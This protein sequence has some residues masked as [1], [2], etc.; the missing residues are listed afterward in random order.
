MTTPTTHPMKTHS[1]CFTLS[2]L[3]YPLAAAIAFSLS[4]P[5]A[6]AQGVASPP[7]PA[8]KV[9]ELSPF[10][11]S[12]S[13]ED[14]YVGQETL[15]G[16]R[17]RTKLSDLAAAIS[18]MTAEF[19][20]DIAVSD[21]GEAVEYAL[22][23][24]Q[25]TGDGSAAAVAGSFMAVE[26]GARGIRIRGLP[27][28][29]RSLNYFSA[30][31]EI[32]T[33]MT[34]GI[35]VSR[36][37]NSI[38][39]GL[40]SPA[41]IVNV[42]SK[43][44]R[45]NKNTYSLSNR[46]DS[47]G[48][49]RWIADANLV[50]IKDKLGMRV[51]VLNGREE[52]WR[53]YGYN[54]QDRIF[55]AAKWAI[56]RK[57]TLKV[58]FEHG[59][60]DDY[61]P[62]P[63]FGLDLTSIW[64]ANNRPI[65]NNFSSN[66]VPGTPGTGQV[67]T[68][69]TPTRNV[70]ANRV[71]GILEIGANWIVV[72][73]R[74]PYAQNYRQFTRADFPVT[75]NVPT[76]DFEMGR[77]N[78][79]AVLEAN[80][81]SGEREQNFGSVYLQREISRNTHLELA[82]NRQTYTSN[83]RNIQWNWNGISADT[84]RYLPNG[85]L[86]PADMLYYVDMASAVG[87]NTEHRTQWRVTLSDERVL[88]RIGRLRLGALGESAEFKQRF[89]MLNQ[90]WLAGPEITSGGAFNPTPENGQNR[91]I[92]RYYL[93]D[94]SESYDPRFTIPG[95]YPI[96][97]SMKYQDPRTGSLTDIYLHE[98][99]ANGVN[100]NYSNR[101]VDSYMGVG[102]LY[103]LRDRLV[104]TFGYR[105]DRL[106]SQ[107][108]RA[109]RDPAAEAIRANT[110]VW[111]I[112][113]PSTAE[114]DYFSGETYTAGAVLHIKPWLAVF[115][116]QSRNRNIPR[117]FFTTPSDPTETATPDPSPTPMG[118]TDDY[119]IKLSLLDNRV[120]VTATTYHTISKGEITGNPARTSVANIW[121]GLANSTLLSEQEAT[122]A[123]GRADVIRQA[124]QLTRNSE[125]EGYELEIVGRPLNGWSVSINYSYA[126][127][128]QS[129]I[130]PEFRAYMDYWKPYWLQYRALAWNQNVN[131][132]RP[133]YAPG[134]EDW[135][136]QDVFRTTNTFSTSIDSINEVVAQAE[137]AFFESAPIFEGRP[138]IGE[139]RHSFNLRTRYDFRTGFL[140]GFSVG[141]GVRVRLDRTAGARAA[142]DFAPGTDYTDV[143]N[144]RVVERTETVTAV[145]QEIFDAQMA[146]S[147]PIFKDKV[148]WRIQLN[149]NNLTDQR[150]L[151]VTNTD[152]VTLAP[153]QYRYQD[154]RQFLLTNTFSF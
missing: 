12:A 77:R 65:F 11:V 51:V 14:G 147:R 41:G 107:I 134:F 97:S 141:G 140:K 123:L 103:L 111:R 58:D 42:S 96:M 27:G 114:P 132:P 59:K 66:Y 6:P 122:A 150:D 143:W 82:F 43:Q 60:K 44:A 146:Y 126:K 151:I 22:G 37:P 108:G 84:N 75:P 116:N 120:F 61:T 48:G 13:G 93:N 92:H 80:W 23:T 138:F 113:D 7:S 5:E 109:F 112:E 153:R 36:G 18:P 32:D 118:T 35:E 26:G 129:D 47:W 50:A 149:I 39:Y 89:D 99:N 25:D 67:G 104:G 130:G 56:D 49:M 46:V 135:T 69:G 90:F 62:R 64:E 24:R 55:M 131:Q 154:P 20:R 136:T 85:N 53:S 3:L 21:V 71:D 10:E 16:S 142:W 86:K 70:G 115:Y 121:T 52:S 110:G 17:V 91:V 40:G 15:S 144:G 83:V 9:V 4:L 31:N 137:R 106:K 57:T 128:A 74:F 29:S 105:S 145:D 45:L 79:K 100:P 34:E 68:P 73:D 148:M 76:P 94:I 30:P 81:V 125:S 95:P 101:R 119:G 88:P 38:L 98:F 2:C 8:E 1:S 127:T 152:P 124:T 19:L 102:Q 133:Q 87:Q 33:Y 28:G 54:D 63:Y 78:P 117:T 72:S 139:P